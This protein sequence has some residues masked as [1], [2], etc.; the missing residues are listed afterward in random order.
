M[1]KAS[2]VISDQNMYDKY[3]RILEMPNLTDKEIGDMHHHMKL[4]A[5]T[6]CEHVWKKQL[7]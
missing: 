5:I 7:Y 6:I 3:R 4:L 1:K 2:I